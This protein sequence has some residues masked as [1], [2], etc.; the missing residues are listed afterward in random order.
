MVLPPKCKFLCLIVLILSTMR[1]F[2][3]VL[4]IYVK[5]QKFVLNESDAYSIQILMKISSQNTVPFWRADCHLIFSMLWFSPILNVFTSFI[6]SVV[7]SQ[8]LCEIDIRLNGDERHGNH[9]PSTSST[10]SSASRKDQQK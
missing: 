10:S 5:F 7:I 1:P 3:T 2:C 9:R 8:F 6:H 4:D